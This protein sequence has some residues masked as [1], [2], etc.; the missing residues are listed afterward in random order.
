MDSVQEILNSPF[1]VEVH[2]ANFVNYLEVVILKD[3]TIEYA[4][5]S[6]QGKLQSLVKLECPRD[7]WHRYLEWLLEQSEAIAVWTNGYI[8]SPNARQKQS[9]LMLV[10]EGLMNFNKLVI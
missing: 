1:D 6:H 3:G 10:R 8:G 7:Q 5:P 4:V 9:I 2:K